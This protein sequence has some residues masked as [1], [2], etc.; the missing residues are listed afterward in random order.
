M[1]QVEAFINNLILSAQTIGLAVGT[2]CVCVIG[3]QVWRAAAQESY[4]PDLIG[5]AC[6]VCAAAILVFAAG[7]IMAWIKSQV[8]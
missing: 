1:S 7:T 6:K 2:L 3:Y 8:G 4:N 5:K